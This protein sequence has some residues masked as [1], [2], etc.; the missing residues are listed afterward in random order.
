MS[1][2]RNKTGSGLLEVMIAVAL[3]AILAAATVGM[4][5]AGATST[6]QGSD[7]VV[8]A[9]LLQEGV[10]AVRSIRYQDFSLIVNGTHGLDTSEGF[11]AFSGTAE[12][13]FDDVYTRT[14]TVED[15]FRDAAG[16]IADAG[17][18]DEDTRKVTVNVTWDAFT[19]KRQNIDTVFYIHNFA[20]QQTWVQTLLAEFG[21][22]AFN[23]ALGQAGGGNGE[24]VMSSVEGAW[25]PLVQE[26]SIDMTG[27]SDPVAAEYDAAQDRLYVLTDNTAGNEFIAYD[28]GNVSASVPNVIGG[29]DVGG[30]Q[31]YDVILVGGYA[32]IAAG[33][34]SA[35]VQVVRLSDFSHV[36]TLD[37]PGDGDAYSLAAAAS[38]L[39]IGR[40]QNSDEELYFYD[41][42]AP[43]AGIAELGSTEL[44]EDCD[45]VAAG[46]GFAF[47]GSGGSNEIIIVSLSGYSQVNAVDLDGGGDVMVLT[48]HETSLFVGRDNNGSAHDFYELDVSSPTGS[49]SVINSLD[50]NSDVLDMHVDVSQGFAFLGTDESSEALTIV[51]LAS[52][53]ES[54]TAETIG[55]DDGEAI[56]QFGAFVFLLTSDNSGELNIF[57]TNPGG[58][59]NPSLLAQ[60]DLS[61]N[62]DAYS[63]YIDGQF[64][65]IGRD[66]SSQ[67]ELS[68]YDISTPSTPVLLGSFDVDADV[69][70][71]V[72]SGDYAYLATDDNSRELDIIDV[73]IKTSPIRVGSYDME[74]D[75]DATSIDI[76]GTV[77]Y[78]GREAQS[79]G[80]SGSLRHEFWI[81]DVSSPSSPARVGSLDYDDDINDI[82]VNG[83]YAYVATEKNDEEL[84][85][86]DI[87]SPVSPTAVAALDISGNDDAL[88]I[89]VSGE[90][91]ALGREDGSSDELVLIDISSPLSPALLGSA[92]VDADI[93][94]IA[95]GANGRAFLATDENNEEFQIWDVS[96]PSAID[97]MAVL[98][99]GDDARAIFFDGTHAHI[100]TEG[101][102]EYQVIGPGA[103]P[104][105][106]PFAA[107]FTSQVFDSESATTSWSQIDWTAST[108]AG[109][110]IVFRVRTASSEAG[111]ETAEWVGPDGTRNTSYTSSGEAVTTDAGATGTQWLQ[112]KAYLSG[113]G[114]ATPA[115]QDVTMSYEQ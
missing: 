9:G 101:D 13:F 63:V 105:G 77:V 55:R 65:Y 33:D 87:S 32:Y 107:T 8:A 111:L 106:Y 99:L 70:D 25:T 88:S 19:G 44:G 61:G 98:N 5:Y 40:G 96:D 109:T 7:Y 46:G 43:E 66:K 23:S 36:K 89:S 2:S 115:L 27:D 34:D 60:E 12:S 73:S 103:G 17:E 112:W 37:L 82:A 75:R 51:D 11:F 59:T 95:L 22:G 53:T 104:G 90:M 15:V 52:F 110:A 62:S 56:V 4:M 1:I 57:R 38:T 26:Y 41:I 16:A 78:L 100:A 108:P 49:I 83:L 76:D 21:I 68:I 84:V 42:T 91:V 29:Y 94:S 97:R 48:L 24:V 80:S 30:S 54:V 72:V 28:L 10:E 67:D 3:F 69:N 79:G 31:P 35:E 102:N 71:L 14:I 47:C 64:A 39:I 20:L 86:I 93:N 114:S 58:W 113:N 18:I 92:A 45:A 74:R 50:T 85:V 81:I 6:K